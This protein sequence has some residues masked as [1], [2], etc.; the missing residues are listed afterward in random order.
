MNRE[1]NEPILPDD[2][3]VYGGYLYVVDGKVFR[4]DWDCI[5]V[6]RL[7]LALGVKEIRRCDMVG[8]GYFDNSEVIDELSKAHLE[9]VSVNSSNHKVRRRRKSRRIR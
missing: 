9:D 8:R 2:Y 6:R 7:K 4:S 1:L 5:T 3:P